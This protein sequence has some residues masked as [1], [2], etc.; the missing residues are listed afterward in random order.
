MH[1][2]LVQSCWFP[3]EKVWKEPLQIWVLLPM[4]IFQHYSSR[5]YNIK[6]PCVYTCLPLSWMYNWYFVLYYCYSICQGVVQHSHRTAKVLENNSILGHEW[7]TGT[8]DLNGART[9]IWAQPR[10]LNFQQASWPYYVFQD[11]V[12][13]YFGEYHNVIIKMTKATFLWEKELTH[14]QCNIPLEWLGHSPLSLLS[15]VIKQSPEMSPLAGVW[16]RAGLYTLT[17]EWGIVHQGCMDTVRPLAEWIYSK[18]FK[19]L[20]SFDFRLRT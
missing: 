7:N 18:V 3:A 10:L 11:N 14:Q 4:S 20:S 13:A 9:R 19:S 12:Q 8:M 6:T 1:Q 15:R 17:C 5:F 2:N 16:T